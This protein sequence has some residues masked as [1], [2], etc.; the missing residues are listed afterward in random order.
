MSNVTTHK[1]VSSSS[2]KDITY[3]YFTHNAPVL[4]MCTGQF[5]VD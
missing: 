2:F 3:S 4:K 5:Y 1:R